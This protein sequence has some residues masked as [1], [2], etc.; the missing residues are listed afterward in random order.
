[1]IDLGTLG[2]GYS[3]AED[4]NKRGQVVGSS[5]TASGDRHAVLWER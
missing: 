3:T 1:M 5:E 4:I 2:G